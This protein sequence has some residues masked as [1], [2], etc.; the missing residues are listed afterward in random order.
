[1]LQPMDLGRLLGRERRS[2]LRRD[3]R[4]WGGRLEKARAFFGAALPASC[5]SW[6]PWPVPARPSP[7]P[8]FE[9]LLIQEQSNIRGHLA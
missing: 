3:R 6:R 4:E 5:I 9:S 7:S 8:R 2:H 1:M